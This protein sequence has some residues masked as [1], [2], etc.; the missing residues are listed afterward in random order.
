MNDT[1]KIWDDRDE[2]GKSFY[3]RSI[4]EKGEMESS[5]A[6]AKIVK[7]LI[8][9]NNKVLDI[10]CG[11]GHYLVSLD[12]TIAKSISEIP[13]FLTLPNSYRLITSSISSN[14]DINL[15]LISSYFSIL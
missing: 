2:Y 4:G 8:Q 12:K 3:L 15:S 11:G 10:G 7:S 9:D 6:T 1:W 13:G 14:K 5:K